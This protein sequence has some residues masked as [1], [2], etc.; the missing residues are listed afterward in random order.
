[1]RE[2]TQEDQILNDRQKMWHI[3][4][5]LATWGSVVAA[6]CLVGMFIFLT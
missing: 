2:L 3:F 4:T 1:M 6:V 5:L